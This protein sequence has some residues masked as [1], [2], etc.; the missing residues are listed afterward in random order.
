MRADRD[1]GTLWPV[2]TLA[3]DTPP[4]IEA[5]L[6]E[7]YRRMSPREKLARVT[8]LNRAAQQMALLRI[9]REYPNATE[10]ER[11]LRLASLWLT[12]EQMI[13]A[14]NWDPDEKGY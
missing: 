10:R 5:I 1:R 11:Q 13:S 9:A 6:I 8:E 2:R 14:F 12:R 4:E 7:G 3:D